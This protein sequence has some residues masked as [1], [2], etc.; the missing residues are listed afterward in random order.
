MFTGSLHDKLAPYL[1]IFP[2]HTFCRGFCCSLVMKKKRK[3]MVP[4]F[5]RTVRFFQLHLFS[6]DVLLTEVTDS[7][8]C[9]VLFSY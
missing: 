9:S 2:E 1:L 4:I 5:V 7:D 8:R 6:S 3:G